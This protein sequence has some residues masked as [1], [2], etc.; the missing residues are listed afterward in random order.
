MANS[1]C[2]VRVVGIRWEADGVVEVAGR[3]VMVAAE[4]FDEAQ[5]VALEPRVRGGLSV[6]IGVDVGVGAER[7]HDLLAIV[8]LEVVEAVEA[9]VGGVHVV[10]SPSLELQF[11][12]RI[13]VRYGSFSVHSN[14]SSSVDQRHS[15]PAL[16][17]ISKIA[18]CIPLYGFLGS[19]LVSISSGFMD[20]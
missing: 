4:A 8:R 2:V 10:E 1:P 20:S 12:V 9:S 15:R 19:A 14:R 11:L 17:S 7:G 18:V 13:D 6:G 16:A 3:E 5:E